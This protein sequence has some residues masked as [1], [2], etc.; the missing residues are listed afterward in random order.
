MKGYCPL[1]RG[2]ILKDEKVLALARKYLKTPAQIAIRW[3]IQVFDFIL[4]LKIL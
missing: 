3:S 1:G 4:I 2:V